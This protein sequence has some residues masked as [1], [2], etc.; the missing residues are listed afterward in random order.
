MATAAA[1]VVARSRRRAERTQPAVKFHAHSV[2][3]ESVALLRR[4]PNVDYEAYLQRRGGTKLSSDGVHRHRMRRGGKLLY[5][6][7]CA[8]RLCDMH[9]AGKLK[10]PAI[11]MPHVVQRSYLRPHGHSLHAV[12]ATKACHLACLLAVNPCGR[13][14]DYWCWRRFS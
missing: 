14:M 2:N 5:V 3:G 8:V 12:A 10:R 7:D 6:A 11:W 4:V 13:D 9:A 1:A